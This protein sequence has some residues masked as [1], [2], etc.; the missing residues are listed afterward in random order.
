[1]LHLQKLKDEKA[2]DEQQ[3]NGGIVSLGTTDLST[4]WSTENNL[5]VEFEPEE[6]VK[7]ESVN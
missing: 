2:K 6:I 4:T 1:M 5:K 3:N 7:M